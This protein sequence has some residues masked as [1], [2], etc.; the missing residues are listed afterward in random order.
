MKAQLEIRDGSLAGQTVLLDRLGS[1]TIGRR[2]A[3]DLSIVEQ[4]VS[5]RHCR[6][7]FDGEFYWLVDCDSHNGTWVNGD[8]I[9]KCML[10][11]GDEIRVGH[12]HMVFSRPETETDVETDF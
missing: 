12:V 5:R 6:V 8:R 3:N 4:A 10:H 1:Y 2:S 9:R 11:D 7:D